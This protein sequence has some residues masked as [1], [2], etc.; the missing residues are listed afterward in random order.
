[1]V[2]LVALA[3]LALVVM[4]AGQEDAPLLRCENQEF[5]SDSLPAEPSSPSD[6][7]IDTGREIHQWANTRDGYEAFWNEGGEAHIGVAEDRDGWQ[8]AV[9][10]E[11]PAVAVHV[12]EVPYTAAEL[13]A[14]RD[15]AVGLIHAA[16]DDGTW[17][18]FAR[19]TIEPMPEV[20]LSFSAPAH[21]GMAFIH[22]D[23]LSPERLELLDEFR[24]EPIC[25]GQLRDEE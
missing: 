9:E 20:S 15:R 6:V 19:E 14:V 7:D 10:K 1:M 11:F 8:T 25:F 13:E 21:F 22:V 2:G 12:I 23:V 24:G 18:S 16:I 3:G 4:R 5:L 17:G